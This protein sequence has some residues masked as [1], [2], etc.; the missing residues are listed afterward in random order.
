[1]ARR[2]RFDIERLRRQVVLHRV[3]GGLSCNKTHQMAASVDA[4]LRDLDR[5]L[6]LRALFVTAGLS[7]SSKRVA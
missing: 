1:M 6:H 5:G 4:I 3:K 7:E 2:L